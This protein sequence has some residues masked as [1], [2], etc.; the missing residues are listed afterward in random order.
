MAFEHMASGSLH[1]FLHSESAEVHERMLH[2]SAL[3]ARIVAEAA[4][5]LAYLHARSIIHRDVKT[6]NV[7]LDDLLRAK[8]A[9]FGLATHFGRD[10]YTAEAGTYRQMAP[11]IVLRRPYN[12]KCDVYSYGVLLWE[13]L[14]PGQDPFSDLMPLQ[15]AFAV[16]MQHARPAIELR[17]DL[18][19]YAGLIRAVRAGAGGRPRVV[20][21]VWHPCLWLLPRCALA[22]A[23]A[24]MLVVAR[25]A[26][27]QCW[28]AEPANRPEMQAVEAT[29]AQLLAEL[30]QQTPSRE[31]PHGRPKVAWS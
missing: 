10:E 30:Q 15:A 24:L 28:D 18:E 7:L 29:T 25:R 12:H 1:S 16:A 26:S 19:C 31:G 3:L 9:D 11:E 17:T 5:G 13:T 14:H 2:E 27:R 21:R 8:V 4:S 20:M 22:L 23:A 6:A